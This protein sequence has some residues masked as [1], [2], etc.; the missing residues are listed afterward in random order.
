MISVMQGNSC[1]KDQNCSKLPKY[2]SHYM[3]G[4]GNCWNSIPCRFFFC[5]I[6]VTLSVWFRLIKTT[7]W[8]WC[9][10]IFYCCGFNREVV[11]KSRRF[12]R[13]HEHGLKVNHINN[14]KTLQ[15]WTR[16]SSISEM[17]KDSM[18]IW[19]YLKHLKS[20]KMW[21]LIWAITSDRHFW[22][23]DTIIGLI[24]KNVSGCNRI[25]FLRSFD[26]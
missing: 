16:S 17:P 6:L 22:T 3:Q 2:W 13:N 14:N 15:R 10:I 5:G 4:R 8:P 26:C 24:I 7:S 18:I 25:G 20:T 23:S 21:D 12:E 1:Q 11:N 9:S 19:D